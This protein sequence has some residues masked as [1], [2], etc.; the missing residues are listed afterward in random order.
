MPQSIPFIEKY[1]K[2]LPY[3][4]LIALGIGALWLFFAVLFEPLLPFLLAAHHMDLLQQRIYVPIAEG[5]LIAH[6]AVGA[7]IADPLA[8]GNVDIQP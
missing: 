1:K 7:E 5:F 8:K 4:P 2:Y 3:L 6:L